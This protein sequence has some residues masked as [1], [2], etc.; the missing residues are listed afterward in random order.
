M[1]KSI[2]SIWKKG[3]LEKNALVAPKINDLYN[4]KSQHI[5]DKF[6]RTGKT[7]FYSILVGAC[8][9]LILSFFAGVPYAG[10][11][12]FAMLGA[13]MLVSKKQAE[14]LDKIDKGDSSYEYL[15]DFNDWLKD[16]MATYAKLYKYL[17]PLFFLV[18]ILGFTFSNIAVYEGSNVVDKIITDPDTYLWYG[19]PIFWMLPI[20]AFTMLVGLFSKRI[21]QFD[22]NIVY[23]N[24]I[25][26]VEEI[27]LEME[28]LRK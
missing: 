12:I 14:A 19:L 20:I 13:V 3:F 24:M 9:V 17:Y 28:D 4:Q 27:L 16:S 10:L 22:L 18:F 21:Y 26:K 5:I 1:E 15:K 11:A 25:R 6:K 7:N 8:V 2:E 23:G